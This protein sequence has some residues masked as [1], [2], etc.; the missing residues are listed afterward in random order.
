MLYCKATGWLV[1]AARTLR[2]LLPALRLLLRTLPRQQTPAIKRP[3]GQEQTTSHQKSIILLIAATVS[4][5]PN[6]LS[7]LVLV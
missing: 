6:A 7:D 1:A 2:S 3:F 5:K 4:R